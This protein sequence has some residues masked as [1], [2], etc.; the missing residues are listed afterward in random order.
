[1]LV[2]WEGLGWPDERVSLRPHRPCNGKGSGDAHDE[3]ELYFHCELSVPH[4]PLSSTPSQLPPPITPAMRPL[5]S[6]SLSVCSQSK[7]RHAAHFWIPRA[8]GTHCRLCT[9]SPRS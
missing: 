7:F 2:K 8:A 3:E 1:M 9:C 5:P 6:V 4:T